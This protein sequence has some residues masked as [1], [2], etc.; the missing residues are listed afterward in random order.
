MSLKLLI[1]Y[2]SIPLVVLVLAGCS[3]LFPPQ[4]PTPYPTEY[5]PTVIALTVEAGR[6]AASE[7]SPTPSQSPQPRFPTPSPSPIAPSP[8]PRTATAT[9]LPSPT[10]S[11]A[12]PLITATL[13]RRPTRTPTITPTPGIPPAD[14]Q[15]SNP[16]PMSRIAS[17]M[18]VNAYLHTIP[19]GSLHVEIWAEPLRAGEEPRLLL[20]QVTNFISNPAPWIYYSEELDFELARVSE[21]AQLRISTYDSHGRPVAATSV[22]L[23][24]IAVGESQLT[25]SGDLL[26]SIVIREPTPNKLI[27]GG[28]LIVSG[29]VR[30]LSE[31]F[32]LIELVAADGRV[33]GYRQ[34]FVTPSPDGIHVPFTIDVPYQVSEPTWVRLTISESNV[35]IPGV[36][37][38]ASVEILLSP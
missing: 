17:P 33:V 10:P 6:R 12:F 37:Q 8:V 5:V 22:D 35:R 13:T 30:P 27:Q 4:G 1:R 14:I 20:R 26:E 16:G 31:Q 9:A 36:S 21:F 19:D 23:V 18:Q 24:L 11:P 29:L 34:L 25:P 38:L 28:T 32:L 7:S 15:I 2:L 3:S